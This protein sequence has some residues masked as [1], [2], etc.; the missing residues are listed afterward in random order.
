MFHIS[1]ELNKANVVEDFKKQ[2]LT[3]LDVAA[4]VRDLAVPHPTNAE[5]PEEVEI[6]EVDPGANPGEVNKAS[7][8]DQQVRDFRNW[9]LEV[10]GPQIVKDLVS[11]GS[12][13]HHGNWEEVYRSGERFFKEIVDGAG[14][15]VGYGWQMPRQIGMG[16]SDF[17][18]GLADFMAAKD[19]AGRE[20]ALNRIKD[21]LAHTG[22]AFTMFEA[23]PVI[24]YLSIKDH[25]EKGHY[26]AAFAEALII[27]GMF[28]GMESI[29]AMPRLAAELPGL[30]KTGAVNAKRA[31][32]DRI[33]KG[34]PTPYE[35]LSPYMQNLSRGTGIRILKFFSGYTPVRWAVSTVAGWRSGE[36][37]LRLSNAVGGL[38]IDIVPNTVEIYEGEQTGSRSTHWRI[39]EAGR[40]LKYWLFQ[41]NYGPSFSDL[42]GGVSSGVSSLGGLPFRE[43]L[44]A[45]RGGQPSFEE[46]SMI[47]KLKIAQA[48]P[49]G[50]TTL[51]IYRASEEFLAK[52]SEQRTQVGMLEAENDPQNAARLQEERIKLASLETELERSKTKIR[53]KN[54]D[55]VGMVRGGGI[56]R[57]WHYFKGD[58]ERGS[59]VE[60]NRYFK[61][62]KSIYK[63]HESEI[64][65]A[66]LNRP[67]SISA[68]QMMREIANPRLRGATK[69]YPFGIGGRTVHLR[70]DQVAKIVNAVLRSEP[71]E[72]V[73]EYG[74][75]PQEAEAIGH[76]IQV[77]F[78]QEKHKELWRL[79]RAGARWKIAP[80]PV[81]EISVADL[82]RTNFATVRSGRII[83]METL[84]G[85]SPD[86]K[87]LLGGRRLGYALVAH[88]F[89]HPDIASGNGR[90]RLSSQLFANWNNGAP[91]ILFI[92]SEGKASL[93]SVKERFAREG[94]GVNNLN[95]QFNDLIR[96]NPAE[97]EKFIQ[98]LKRGNVNELN[99]PEVS[100]R[101]FNAVDLVM[102]LGKVGTSN[103]RRSVSVQNIASDGP[104]VSVVE[105]PP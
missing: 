22:A 7:W 61:A 91:Q 69:V 40:Q 86:V 17:Y 25:L 50:H 66:P 70:G 67:Q 36:L 21:G 35:P 73:R 33:I 96:Q 100:G 75:T 65:A 9:T 85:I 49:N 41:K 16:L 38:H 34:S 104:S 43:I 12:D 84:A 88:E 90:I 3:S 39:T 27:Y 11:F 74:L 92:D 15:V 80:P 53:I 101:G 18:G 98:G 54:S 62:L 56:R 83:S 57:F 44:G 51:E 89:S 103:V 46:A 14:N 4:L 32:W 48:D 82:C 5:L 105:T 10:Y 1:A 71:L 99:L 72:F 58:F 45:T 79:A 55:F 19:Q 8:F 30:V 31:F 93:L 29:K 26:G 52:I 102:I 68:V 97:F 87:A 2:N 6:M 37:G 59:F 60:L 20:K 81:V 13:V 42:W 47:E 77:D 94:I 28:G 24:F 95:G 78:G 23:F 63:A 76:E 64:K